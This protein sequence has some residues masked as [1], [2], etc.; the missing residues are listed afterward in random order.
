MA[1]LQITVPALACSAW[2]KVI[3]KAIKTINAD[4]AE[5]TIQTDNKTK[6]VNVKTQAPE[7]AIKK[8]LAAAG[9]PTI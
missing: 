5:A 6:L 9:Y 7:A 3:T 2:V 4:N 1:I 8:A